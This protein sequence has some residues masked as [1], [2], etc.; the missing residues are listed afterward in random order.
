MNNEVWRD[1][2]GYEGY[3]Q[4]SNMGRV[5]S[6]RNQ[7]YMKPSA[8]KDG[9]L[10]VTLTAKNGKRKNEKVHRL[11]ALAFLDNPNGFPQVNHKDKIRNNN[12]LE[13]LEWCS[14]LYNITYSKGKAIKCVELDKE[15]P[16]S[17]AASRELGIDGGSIRK[18]LSGARKTAGGYHWIYKE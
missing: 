4:V 7:M 1:C 5:W 2:K 8:D 18:C 6:V 17:A 13:N 12:T 3:Y 16:S 9:Y 15:F 14:A 10:N 11:V